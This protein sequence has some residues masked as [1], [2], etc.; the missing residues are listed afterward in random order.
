[1]SDKKTKNQTDSSDKSLYKKV[2]S[3]VSPI[4]EFQAKLFLIYSHG[5]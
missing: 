2:I 3:K 5:K 4:G 1:M